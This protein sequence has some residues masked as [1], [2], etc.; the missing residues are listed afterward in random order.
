MPKKPTFKESR[1]HY[2]LPKQIISYIHD[3]YSKLKGRVKTKD[4]ETEEFE[5]LRGVFQGDPYSGTIFLIIFNPLIEYIKSMKE[6]KGYT[7]ETKESLANKEETERT[8][9]ITTPFADYFNLISR[10]KKL[11]QKLIKDIETKAKTMGLVF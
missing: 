7:L 9:I 11:H 10:N 8:N 5:F 1:K 6:K 3:I 4:W 2:Y